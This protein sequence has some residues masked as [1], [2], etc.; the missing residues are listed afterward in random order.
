MVVAL[1]QLGSPLTSRSQGKRVVERATQFRTVI[2]DFEGIDMVG[3][4]FVDEVF[5]VFALAHPEVRLVPCNLVP[6]VA[7]ML[8]L[9]AP[10]IDLG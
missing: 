6:A 7:N 4:G 9:F 8:R 1:A 10:H 5:R 3:Q 2:L